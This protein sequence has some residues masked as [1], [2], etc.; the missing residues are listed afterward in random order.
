MPSDIS[1]WIA[2]HVNE[3]I[4]VILLMVVL[5]VMVVLVVYFMR[6]TKKDNLE[7]DNTPKDA[8]QVAAPKELHHDHDLPPAVREVYDKNPGNGKIE[9]DSG[10]GLGVTLPKGITTLKKI[11]LKNTEEKLMTEINASA[12]HLREEVIRVEGSLH[13]KLHEIGEGII[14]EMYVLKN[15]VTQ[16]REKT[17]EIHR[18]T[19]KATPKPV[20]SELLREDGMYSDI[21]NPEEFELGDLIR[22]H[23]GK[24]GL[25]KCSFMIRDKPPNP[26]WMH[27]PKDKW[28]EQNEAKQKKD[29]DPSK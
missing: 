19:S 15:E 14:E 18:N 4:L 28:N 6:K 26:W 11:H 8:V 29:D 13:K 25:G 2:D 12:K 21:P 24:H 17:K 20:A 7:P 27:L 23:T 22:V 3:L 5:F 10:S 1:F 9:K 16:I